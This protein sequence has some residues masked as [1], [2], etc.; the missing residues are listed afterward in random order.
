MFSFDDSVGKEF[1]FWIFVVVEIVLWDDFE[2]RWEVLFSDIFFMM[3]KG[4]EFIE[5]LRSK[6]CM[7]DLVRLGNMCLYWF[8]VVLDLDFLGCKS[9][10][11]IF[12][13]WR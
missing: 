12:K 8:E 10:F 9:S 5:D 2:L 3:G 7:F 1:E 13:I 6:F 11:L 4:V